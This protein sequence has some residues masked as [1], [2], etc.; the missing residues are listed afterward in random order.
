AS[1]FFGDG[2]HL[3]NVSAAGGKLVQS[4]IWIGN[5]L[6]TAKAAYTWGDATLLYDA[7]TDSAKIT[8]NSSIPTAVTWTAQQTFSN[9]TVSVST[10]ITMT[11]AAGTLTQTGL[12][13]TSTGI[14]TTGGV[15]AAFFTGDG[16]GLT[17]ISSENISG[18]PTPDIFSATVDVA[19]G[20]ALIVS[21]SPG[22]I[23]VDVN[24]S[25]VTLQGNEFNGSNELVLLEP[26]GDL[27]ALD[28][29]ALFNLDAD[30]LNT[31]TIS[32]GIIWNGATV[33]VPYGGTGNT[34]FTNNG[35]LIGKGS[36]AVESTPPLG[37]G[38]L[39]IG[40]GTNSTP[41]TGTLT[42]GSGAITITNMPGS[43]TLDVNGSSVAL[44]N[45]TQTFTAAHDFT[46]EVGIL[47]PGS[48]TMSGSSVTLT[49]SAGVIVSVSSITAGA[50]FG[51]GSHL[52]GIQP[53]GSSLA[54]ANIW[55]G[56]ATNL[57]Q[58]HPM[59]GDATMDDTGKV[60]IGPNAINTGKLAADA[61][62]YSAILNGAVQTAK[63]AADAVTYSAILNGAVQTAKLATDAVTTLA[64]LNANVTNIK[65]AADVFSS[66][67]AWSG[68]DT[69]TS[70]VDIAAPGSLTMTGS[71]ITLTGSGGIINAGSSV[72]ASAF[73][74]NGAGLIGVSGTD[75]TKV[76]KAGDT[77]TGNLVVG[78][79]GN[80]STVSVSGYM[81]FANESIAPSATKGG[82]YYNPTS[83]G[84]EG[85]FFV[86]LDGFSW[87]PIATGTAG[88]GL[89]GVASNA[90]Q[91]TG[92]GVTGDALTLKSSSVTLQG[93]SFN[94]TSQLIQT[95]GAG[96]YPAL[97]GSLITNLLG[98]NIQAGTIDTTRLNTDA[99]NSAAILNGS[100]NTNKLALDAVTTSQR[101]A[102]CRR[103]RLGSQLERSADLLHRERH[104]LRDELQQRAPDPQRVRRH[105]HHSV[106][107][108]RLRL[109]GRRLAPHRRHRHRRH[110]QHRQ[111]L[112]RQHRQHR[113]PADRLQRRD[114]RRRRQAHH[115][116]RRHRHRQVGLGRR[117]HGRH[118]RWK[119][120]QRQ[121]GGR[122][123]RLRAYLERPA[124][125][126]QQHGLGQ[127]RDHDDGRR[128]NAHPDQSPLD[129][130]RHRHDGRRQGCLLRRRRFGVDQHLHYQPGRRA[131]A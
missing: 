129:L 4:Q 107:R 42:A 102:Q 130:H 104:R 10:A 25:S 47:A 3:S 40:A 93:N 95:T 80:A 117:H 84:G 64:I 110:P 112:D 113:R 26:D 38:G 101:Q 115:P 100:V 2:S 34:S 51:D 29:S 108:H 67:H 73:F 77:M 1:A 131:D 43:I 69:F 121:A 15:E 56:D 119:R 126:L 46:S 37:P 72:T 33:E 123:V 21:T 57:A 20:P 127:H 124:D 71:S 44:L 60:T 8:L 39:I 23:T 88:G 52:S 97:N 85:A 68:S 106:L 81:T 9:N 83:A 122:R 27:P 53:T 61:V 45:S 116:A 66:S 89:S 63:L 59:S 62:T 82:I 50:F 31:G 96:Y 14:A 118:P 28:G 13:S 5:N 105:H 87:V 58:Q 55:I 35:V 109:L 48:L 41:S 99:V 114:P 91:F 111:D 120:H 32:N 79:D 7:G 16:S 76:A 75:S 54:D 94:G 6:D 70:E 65:L 19:N 90:D 86:S 103:V 49:G 11:G 74:G 36:N 78:T 24:D 17:N 98:T 128:G 125:L 30:A 92:T 18:I 22:L 12:P